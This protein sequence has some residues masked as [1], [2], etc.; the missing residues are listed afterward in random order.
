MSA[1]RRADLAAAGTDNPFST[2]VNTT[3]LTR[4]RFDV[5]RDVKPTRKRPV[6]TGPDKPTIA[7]LEARCG[8]W[9]EYPGCRNQAQ[10]P[11][12]RDERGQ[13]GRGPKAPDWINNLANLLAACRGHNTWASNGSPAE[14]TAM[15]WLIEMGEATPYTVPVLTRHHPS[16]VW[17]DDEGAWTPAEQVVA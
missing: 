1:R 4:G 15:G 3:P 11:H 7:L 10:D 6:Y 16:K 12:H 14:A 17:L 9:C 5:T 8:G 2:L 13:G